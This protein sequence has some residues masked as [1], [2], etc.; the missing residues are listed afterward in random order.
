MNSTSFYYFNF[1]SQFNSLFN[2]Q[3]V[4]FALVVS[5]TLVECTSLS[6]MYNLATGRR[7]SIFYKVTTMAVL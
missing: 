6:L 2:F 7:L 1:G 5:T 4:S 3:I